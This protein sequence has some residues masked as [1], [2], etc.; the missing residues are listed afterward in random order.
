MNTWWN[1]EKGRGL[2]P[3]PKSRYNVNTDKLH[4]GRRS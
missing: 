2:G 1:E 3:D 4:P